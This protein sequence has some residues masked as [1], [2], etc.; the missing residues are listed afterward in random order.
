MA[1]QQALEIFYNYSK[2]IEIINKINDGK[3]LTAN[4]RKIIINRFNSHSI[5]KDLRTETEKLASI[6][7]I[8]K[9]NKFFL[10]EAFEHSIHAIDFLLAEENRY[11]FH[12]FE[13]FEA[14]LK[15]T[16]KQYVHQFLSLSRT[17]FEADLEGRSIQQQENIIK[18]YIQSITQLMNTHSE[19]LSSEKILDLSR[20]KLAN[21]VLTGLDLRKVYFG[22]NRIDGCDFSNSLVKPEQLQYVKS[23]SKVSLDTELKQQIIDL[24]FQQNLS[25]L[26]EV[27]KIISITRDAIDSLNYFY[28][29][30]DI[31]KAEDI[32]TIL[33]TVSDVHLKHLAYMI[34]NTIQINL[35]PN[36]HEY[37]AMMLCHNREKIFTSSNE[38]IYQMLN[39]MLIARNY[40]VPREVISTSLDQKFYGL[41]NAISDTNLAIGDVE[42]L[43]E[44][45]DSAQKEILIPLIADIK[46]C[47]KAGL[48]D[49]EENCRKCDFDKMADFFLA[50]NDDPDLA[51]EMNATDR[52]G[53]IIKIARELKIPID[54]QSVDLSKVDFN[55]IDITSVDI[56]LTDEQEAKYFRAEHIRQKYK[57]FFDATKA[58]NIEEIK[59]ILANGRYNI[60]TRDEAG[61]TALMHACFYNHFEMAKLLIEEYGAKIDILT[62][63]G[64]NLIQGLSRVKE[65]EGYHSTD[66]LKIIDYL[67]SRNIPLD[68][69]SIAEL[70]DVRTL[71]RFSRHELESFDIVG[72][73]VIQ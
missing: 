26:N 31:K 21:I 14:P 15:Q 67:V 24:R 42:A 40:N 66:T 41:Y 53:G 11:D 20:I 29:L 2:L 23:L 9:S 17:R 28:L 36:E 16:L 65:E 50:L 1:I 22:N 13:Q 5:V 18:Y 46:I 38:E 72:H 47:R 6:S 64:W 59:L 57:P 27:K 58:G 60:D 68:V 12:E 49:Q 56:L 73:A 44:E 43:F 37:S 61:R 54:L 7:E 30:C 8:L 70:G 25:L 19:I 35:L 63:S 51:L 45:F 10:M 3:K 55:N 32:Q 62:N 34:L 71:A 39:T 33:Q 52:L 48:A 4:E 69:H